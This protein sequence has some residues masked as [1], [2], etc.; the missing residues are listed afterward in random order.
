MGQ[1]RTADP[2]G[3]ERSRRRRNTRARPCARS[4]PRTLARFYFNLLAADA[5]LWLLED[6]LK[7]RVQSV[8]LQTDRYQAR[9]HRRLRPRHGAQAERASVA[10]DIAVAKRAVAGIRIRAGGAAGPLAARESSRRS[11]R[12]N[13]AMSWGRRRRR[14]SL[15]NLPSDHARRDV[16]DIRQ[17][18]A[19]LAAA[20]MRDRRGARGLLSAAVAD[21]PLRLASPPR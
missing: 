11:S 3:A 18:E 1:F 16:P 21:R 8:D 19:Q 4:S 15:A 14:R 10:G 20:N 12:R 6:T 7:T 5:Q 13:V 2:G 17:A 9:H